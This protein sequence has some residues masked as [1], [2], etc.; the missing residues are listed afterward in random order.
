ML[1]SLLQRLEKQLWLLDSAPGRI[2]IG[3]P[4]INLFLSC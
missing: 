1:S 2:R 3:L 4:T